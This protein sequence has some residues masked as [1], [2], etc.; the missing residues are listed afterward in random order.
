MKFRRSRKSSTKSST[1]R[2]DKTI[3]KVK[4]SATKKRVSTKT[5]E[6]EKVLSHEPQ[7]PQSPKDLIFLVKWKGN[8]N[9]NTNTNNYTYINIHTLIINQY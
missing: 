6:I 8:T 4:K 2:N 5:F 7:N 3:T 1:K 9:T